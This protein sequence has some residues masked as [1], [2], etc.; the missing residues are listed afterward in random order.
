MEVVAGSMTVLVRF[1]SGKEVVVPWPQSSL[2]AMKRFVLEEGLRSGVLDKDE[3]F[4]QT[5]IDIKLFPEGP[6]LEKP[7]EITMAWDGRLVVSST[8]PADR[9]QTPGALCIFNELSSHE[10]NWVPVRFIVGGE[11]KEPSDEEED[12]DVLVKWPPSSLAALE[13]EALCEAIRAD[14]LRP[15]EDFCVETKIDFFV[16]DTK[17]DLLPSERPH[18]NI[19]AV[20]DEG[21]FDEY[22]YECLLKNEE[23]TDFGNGRFGPGKHWFEE[24]WVVKRPVDGKME[25]CVKSEF[26][27]NGH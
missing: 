18:A 8:P 27:M 4:V 22:L 15:L 24:W 19:I 6:L 20:L 1:L 10:D 25:Y 17:L 26:R 13:D 2:A 21:C 23:V 7:D 5:K 12:D 9:F 3:V 14:L 11:V 16:G